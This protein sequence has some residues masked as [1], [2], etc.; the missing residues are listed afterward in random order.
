MNSTPKYCILILFLFLIQGK[1]LCAQTE[2]DS[3]LSISGQVVSDKTFEPIP[4]A[5]VTINRSRKGAICDS[6]G[7]FHLQVMQDDT[8]KISALGYVPRNWAVPLVLNQ[9]SPPFFQIKLRDVTYLL[10]EIDVFALGTWDEF[11]RR[12]VEKELK[13]ENPINEDL[14]KQLAP[15]NT[16]K[17]DPVPA[18]YKPKR[19]KFGV[20][21]AIFAPTDF[22]FSKLSKSEKSKKRIAKMIRNERKNDKISH[23]YNAEVVKDITGLQGEELVA[24]LEYCGNKI[25]VSENSTEYDVRKQIFDIYKKYKKAVIKE[26]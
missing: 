16:K 14:K 19:E 24:F 10:D 17:P 13:E 20:L 11:A 22:L 2:Q 12:F 5:T 23:L 6:V 9:D 18:M 21:G 26:E 15:Y 1:E 4:L 3:L 25:K 8:L 7:V